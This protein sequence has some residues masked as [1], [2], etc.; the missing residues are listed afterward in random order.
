[1][2]APPGEER[3]SPLVVGLVL[4]AAAAAVTP[5]AVTPWSVAALRAPPAPPG[6]LVLLALALPLATLAACW[7]WLDLGLDRSRKAG[8][9]TLVAVV[10]ALQVHLH[11]TT[12]DRG[13]FVYAARKF[14]DNT[15]WQRLMQRAVLEGRTEGPFLGHNAR[16]LP[17]G[18]TQLLVAA[19]GD[20]VPARTLYRLT[21][22]LLLLLAIYA[23][24]RRWFSHATAVG[25]VLFYAL[26]YPISIRHYA[27]QLTDPMSHLSLVLGLVL[28]ARGPFAYLL[29][30][31]GVGTIAKETVAI[32][33]P[34][35][36]V[37][38]PDDPK[39]WPRA[40]VLTVV[41]VGM[42]WLLRKAVVGEVTEEG[43]SATTWGHVATNLR[44]WPAW[45][46]QIA[47]TLLPGGLFLALG[48]GRTP[49]A[50]RTT[51]VYLT[52]VLLASS[53]RFS[54][55][56]EAR[57]FV[58]GAIPMGIVAAAWLLG[59]LE[60]RADEPAR[61]ADLTTGT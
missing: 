55:L 50:L 61:P 49:P 8:L 5:V 21:F 26:I 51:C 27:G 14:D 18:F 16:F 22:Q 25:G 33:G 13:P 40:A 42:V 9:F 59:E 44:A 38:R 20:Y 34:L 48:W 45:I 60:G 24:G 1:M 30:C 4:L 17:N 2:T 15:G 35:Y 31:I 29:L 28:L 19:T 57:N 3:A 41:G 6:L 52:V 36:V 43:M 23:L 37:L 12:V 32:L 39:R 58:P 54:W 7:R 56:Y 11:H 46:P 53:L 47:L 10:T